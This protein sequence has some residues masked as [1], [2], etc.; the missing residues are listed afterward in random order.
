MAH[1]GFLN[2]CAVRVH[3]LPASILPD[4]DARPAAL[5]VDRSILI[6]AFSSGAIG[7]Y[8]CIA[9]DAD[10]DVIGDQRIEIHAAALAVLQVLRSGLDIPARAVMNVVLVQNALQE[11]DIRFDDCC[12]EILRSKQR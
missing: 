9:V 7:H 2:R 5:L 10:R 3:E 1:S 12:V 8:R 11:S 6:L 4:E